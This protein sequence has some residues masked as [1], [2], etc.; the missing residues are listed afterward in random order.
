MPLVNPVMIRYYADMI[1]GL[2]GFGAS[3]RPLMGRCLRME[4]LYT[5]AIK[6]IIK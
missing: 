1:H 4:D 6:T 3:R 5:H 2:E